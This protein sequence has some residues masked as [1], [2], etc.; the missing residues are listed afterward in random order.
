M[1]V[2]ASNL[3]QQPRADREVLVVALRQRQVVSRIAKCGAG[4]R[5]SG[6]RNQCVGRVTEVAR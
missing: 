4:I 2:P 3:W 5:R 1:Q 6:R